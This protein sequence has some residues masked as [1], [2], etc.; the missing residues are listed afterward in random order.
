MYLGFQYRFKCIEERLIENEE[1]KISLLT[2]L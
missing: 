1:R 2:T